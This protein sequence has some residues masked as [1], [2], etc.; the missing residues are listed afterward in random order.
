MI[1]LNQASER[2]QSTGKIHTYTQT[3]TYTYETVL[4]RERH[5]HKQRERK[6]AM[7]L[8]AYIWEHYALE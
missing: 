3:F 2:L 1:F 8:A 7:C 6:Q 5:T 4:L